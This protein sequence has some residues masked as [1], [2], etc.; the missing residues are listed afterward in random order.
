MQGFEE[1]E[2][3]EMPSVSLEKYVS[4]VQS[5]KRVVSRTILMICDDEPVRILDDPDIIIRV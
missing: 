2:E 5:S 4:D 1:D 3:Q